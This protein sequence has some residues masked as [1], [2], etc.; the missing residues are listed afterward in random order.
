VA[1]PS[2]PLAPE[3]KSQ[4]VLEPESIAYIPGVPRPDLVAIELTLPPDDGVKR[5]FQR[6][7]FESDG[8]LRYPKHEGDWEPP[9]VPNGYVRDEDDAWR[10]LPLWLPCALRHQSAYLN[11]N[12]G[13]IVIIMRCNNQSVKYYGNRISADACKNC[14]LRSIA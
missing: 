2:P 11:D 3:L 9:P 4:E 14:K 5:S 8:T 7:I 12:C 10:F 6:P 1:K 13:C